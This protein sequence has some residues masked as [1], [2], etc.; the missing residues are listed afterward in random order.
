MTVLNFV[1]AF[2]INNVVD[3]FRFCERK[4]EN[5]VNLYTEWEMKKFLFLITFPYKYR[6]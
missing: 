2:N 5:N 4:P 1:F 6:L 3:T